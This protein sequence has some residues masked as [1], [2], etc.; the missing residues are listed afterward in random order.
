MKSP[1]PPHARLV[2][3]QL[4]DGLVVKMDPDSGGCWIDAGTYWEWVRR[5]PE[6][7]GT[8]PDFSTV[9]LEAVNDSQCPLIS[10]KSGR[11]MR[12]FDVGFGQSF[13][14]DFDA[15]S[16]AF[17]LDPGELEALRA[18]GLH[19]ALHLICSTSY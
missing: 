11:L 6:F 1:I 8:L 13:R 18:C 10:P 19:D 7:P 2:P 16:G 9:P 14:I 3:K 4:E 12:K 15:A 5:Q 17:W